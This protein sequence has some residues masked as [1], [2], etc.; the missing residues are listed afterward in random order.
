MARERSIYETRVDKA[1][2]VRSFGLYLLGKI[3]DALPCYESACAF[4]RNALLNKRLRATRVDKAHC[5]RSADAG[6]F[7]GGQSPPTPPR[8]QA[9]VRLRVNARV[10]FFGSTPLP[11]KIHKQSASALLSFTPKPPP[12]QSSPHP[13][14]A[15]PPTPQSNTPTPDHKNSTQSP[16]A[17]TKQKLAPPDKDEEQLTHPQQ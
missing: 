14:P 12:S 9:R 17:A 13:P 15:A 1:H 3:K 10:P 11:V 2:F 5:V 16:Q 4:L 8:A 7:A 6:S